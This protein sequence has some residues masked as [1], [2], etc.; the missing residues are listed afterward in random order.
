LQQEVD[1]LTYRS[2]NYTF[3]NP[4]QLEIMGMADVLENGTKSN[5]QLAQ[6]LFVVDQLKGKR[7]G[8][9]VEFGAT[10]GHHL[11]N[12]LLLEKEYGWKGILAEPAKVWQEQLTQNRHCT[13][14]QRC[15]W[16][17]SGETIIFHETAEAELSTADR[18]LDA[19][20]HLQKRGERRSYP[21]QT[22]SLNDLLDEHN[23]P[24]EIDYLSVDTE[25]SEYD[26]LSAFNFSKYRVNII[27]VEHNYTAQ[28]E[29]LFKLLT[30]NGYKRIFESLSQFDDWYVRL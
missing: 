19:D 5:A 6:D 30:G 26:I 24:E 29:D 13:I 23:A 1:R 27:T 9:F 25:G 8:F 22:V 20:W 2:S 21:V 18:F 15:V 3:A 12:T 14:D 4:Q 28:R 16:S 7:E 11:S 10:D 17:V